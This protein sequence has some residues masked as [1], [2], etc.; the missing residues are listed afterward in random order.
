MHINLEYAMYL[1]KKKKSQHNLILNLNIPGLN[2]ILNP[3]CS[4]C[5]DFWE[6]VYFF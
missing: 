4:V 2:L 5:S 3:I 1:L 6:I